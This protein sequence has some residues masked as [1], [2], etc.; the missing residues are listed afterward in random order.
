M[1]KPTDIDARTLTR[2]WF[3]TGLTAL[4]ITRAGPDRWQSSEDRSPASA[5]LGHFFRRDLP[6]AVRLGRKYLE[7]APA[8][9]SEERLGEMILGAAWGEGNSD[10]RDIA[11]R[12][13]VRRD[14]DFRE[15]DLVTIDGWFLART[16]ARLCALAALAA[17]T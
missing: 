13:R 7:I 11:T 9:R 16:E 4:V 8:E 6:A 2:R 14:E 1:K 10:A 5:L 17:N 3:L 15:G 12:V